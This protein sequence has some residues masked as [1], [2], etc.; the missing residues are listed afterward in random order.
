M[1]RLAWVFYLLLAVGAVLWIG[2]RTGRIE[3]G[4]FA[5]KEGW[6]LDGAVGVLGAAVLLGF[7]EGMRRWVPSAAR[8][9]IALADALGP[10]RLDEA[11]ALAALSGFAEELFFR[12]AVLMAWGWFPATV[13]FALLH[14]G[15]G[16]AYRAWTGFAAVAGLLFAGLM[17]WRGNLLAPILAHT[18]VN[19]VNLGRLS[20]LRT[21]DVAESC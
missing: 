14:T 3:P 7:W 8:L 13:F 12:G 5:G 15:P 10:L 4:L 21:D 9:E 20:R 16:A 1:Y 19:G 18:L 17:L 6:L 11:L 2:G